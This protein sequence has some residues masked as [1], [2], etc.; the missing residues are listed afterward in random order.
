MLPILFLTI[1][2]LETQLDILN[3]CIKVEAEDLKDPL[4]LDSDVHI[5]QEPVQEDEHITNNLFANHVIKEEIVVHPVKEEIFIKPM[6]LQHSEIATP[7]LKTQ[8]EI[9][10]KCLNQEVKEL[11]ENFL[12]SDTD[13]HIKQEPVQEEKHIPKEHDMYADHDIKDEVVIGPVV[14]LQS[15]IAEDSCLQNSCNTVN[16]NTR[17]KKKLYRCH[18]C[19]K[20]FKC[21]P[22]MHIKLHTGEKPYE[23]DQ[24]RKCFSRKHH[25]NLH[26]KSHTGEK[27]Y[28]C[29]I[30]HK[31]FTKKH[32]LQMHIMIHTGEKPFQCDN[33]NKSFSRKD[34]LK[35]H[36]A[37]HNVNTTRK[38]YVHLYI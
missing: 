4:M 25:L 28:Q 38:Q 37:T 32:N 14:L 26:L 18:I 13:V 23:C 17:T 12:N 31:Y 20:Y 3:K 5:K 1:P 24:C 27:P 33:C 6:V 16:K 30:C 34:H 35:K 9:K 7:Q 36:S 29:D 15:G 21:N 2:H 10:N 11:K 8:L 19:N 22:K